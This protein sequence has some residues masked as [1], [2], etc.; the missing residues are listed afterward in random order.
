MKLRVKQGHSEA[1][2]GYVGYVVY[3]LKIPWKDILLG[4]VHVLKANL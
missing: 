1:L 2:V 4:G 3:A